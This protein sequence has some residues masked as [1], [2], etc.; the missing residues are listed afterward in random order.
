MRLRRTLRETLKKKTFLKLVAVRIETPIE[1]SYHSREKHP[2]HLPRPPVAITHEPD[3][4]PRSK[5]LA[6]AFPLEEPP[7]NKLDVSRMQL[8]G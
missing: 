6:P 7:L 4:P 8:A 2:T 3:R 1:M 5:K